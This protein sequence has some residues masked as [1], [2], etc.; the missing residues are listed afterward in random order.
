MQEGQQ[1]SKRKR[2]VLFAMAKEKQWRAI[3]LTHS[4]TLQW[5]RA[6]Q[7][8]EIHRNEER[9]KEGH[10]SLHLTLMLGELY[11]AEFL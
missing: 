2:N 4:H 10:C 9:Q 7:G 8:Q 11:K 3:T 6:Q 1:V 5:V